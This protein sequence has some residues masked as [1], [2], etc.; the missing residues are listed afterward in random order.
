MAQNKLSDLNDFLMAQIQVLSNENLKG[1]ELDAELRKSKAIASLSSQV[2]KN[3]RLV[4]DAAKATSGGNIK[5]Q[6]LPKTFELK[7]NG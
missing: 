1:E 2:I 5:Q 6:S 7:D 4:F 3:S